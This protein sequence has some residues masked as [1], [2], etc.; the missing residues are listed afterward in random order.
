MT[1]SQRRIRKRTGKNLSAEERFY[2]ERSVTSGAT[3]AKVAKDL[4]RHRSTI[5]RELRRGQYRKAS[6]RQHIVE[7]SRRYSAQLG[8]ERYLR[9]I[10]RCGRKRRAVIDK[11]FRAQMKRTLDLVKAERY[12]PYAAIERLKKTE[13]SWDVRVDAVYRYL[14]FRAF[15]M[16]PEILPCGPAKKRKRNKRTRPVPPGKRSIE[17]RPLPVNTRE[18]FGH[19]EGDLIVGPRGSKRV[20]LTLVERKTRMPIIRLL[21]DKTTESVQQALDQIEIENADIWDAAFKSSTWDNG[22]EF[23]D[24]GS[25][26]SSV[27]PLLPECS[28][29]GTLTGER[30][31][32]YYAHPYCSKERGS[33]ENLNR[34]VR[35]FVP[36]GTRIE[37]ITEDQVRRIESWIANYP[38]KLLGGR[39]SREAFQE[40]LGQDANIAIG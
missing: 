10:A 23:D 7:Y 1:R 6:K 30:W 9:Q 21:P 15:G 33:S 8:H 3:A 19:W 24:F 28:S 35:R 25:I 34:M 13:E 17:N 36:K 22:P 40:A 32:A 16:G 37:S 14:H 31:L 5:Y 12:S 11:T 29:R 38:R 39:S 18:E 27:D 4:G 20:L 2:I 26:E